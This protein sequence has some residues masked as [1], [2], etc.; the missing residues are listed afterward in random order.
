MSKYINK[1]MLLKDFLNT[2]NYL[3]IADLYKKFCDGVDLC[4]DWNEFFT[5]LEPEELS[6]LS[7]ASSASWQTKSALV[8]PTKVKEKIDE[9]SNKHPH[10]NNL[11]SK[12][13]NLIEAYRNYGHLAVQLDPLG[14]QDNK[15]P[16]E[17]N[18]QTYKITDEE[19]EKGSFYGD[20]CQKNNLTI[21][22]LFKHLV[23]TY[24]GRVGIEF[25]HME[26]MTERDWLR[27]RFE[28]NAGNIH[29]TTMEQ[30]EILQGIKDVDML[31]KFLHTKFPGAKRFSIE[32]AESTITAIEQIIKT[33]AHAGVKEAI[34]G[35][36]HRGRL[37]ILTKVM[38]KPYHAL[39]SEFAGGTFIPDSLN[40]PGDVKYHLG[41]SSDIEVDGKK[42]HLTLTHNPSHLEAVSPVVLGRVRAKQKSFKDDC[43]SEVM[44]ILLHGDAA[45]SGQGS[46][47]ET[48]AL[49]NVEAYKVGGTIH[50]ITNNQIGFTTNA[51]SGRSSRYCTDIAKMI[52]A[53]VLHVSG[54]DPEAVAFAAKIAAEYRL[55]FQKDIF[56]D[57]VCY[58][59]FGHNEGDEPMFTQPI[60]YKKI[61]KK[62][63]VSEMYS[64]DLITKN[65]IT[66]QY[67]EQSKQNFKNF[68]QSEF[69]KS[70]HYKPEEA[71][72]LQSEWKGFDSSL[73]DTN[74]IVKTAVSR[75][76]VEKLSSYITQIP[77]DFNAH[78]KIKKIFQQRDEMLSGKHDLDWG[79][80]ETLAYAT[81]LSDGFNIRI[82]GQDVERGTFSHRHATIHDQLSNA[83]Y[84]PLANLGELQKGD[85]E[86][87]NSILS[88]FGVLG[89]E[90]GYSFSSPNTLVIWEA[91]FGDFANGAQVI[92]DQFIVSGKSKWMRMSGLVML[93]PHGYEGQG[94]EHSSARLERFLQLCANDNITV[95]NCTTPASFFHLLRRQMLRK[96]RNPLVVMTPKSFLRHKLA[97]SSLDDFVEKVTFEKLLPDTLVEK[98]IKRIIFCSGKVYYDLLEYRNQN[99]FKNVALVRLEQLYP[100]PKK[101]VQEELQRYH[102]IKD[103]VWCQEEHKN[104]GAWHY[105]RAHFEKAI[106]ASKLEKQIIYI[107]RKKSASPAAGHVKLHQKELAEFI[108]E[109]FKL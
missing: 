106:A 67:F 21:K 99:E 77:E 109:A 40:L 79:M 89:F 65:V 5:A 50:V 23:Q 26:N 27:D 56:I 51:K 73:N 96:V 91:Q 39:F 24:G 30:Q 42:I 72:W 105:I 82:T 48:L 69:D 6:L 59:K 52:S 102:N 53:P 90:Y 54:D 63:P 86:I 14:L 15:F 100:F 25:C 68:L 84:T 18:Y 85:F 17:L 108:S 64:Q 58:R 60:M 83:K 93:L 16:K 94:P 41:S 75:K 80:G 2:S 76:T 32:G 1:E 11:Q 88:E 57:I 98:K 9:V 31:E 8:P 95:A 46:V 71:D 44:A 28:K 61:Q 66:A 37:S 87:H 74:S 49:S 3:Y 22:E 10:D 97:V 43:R 104:M 103:I 81:L 62:I 12:V 33:S 20:F 34:F 13:I 36:A 7:Q 47:M 70:K 55:H 35:M 92:I 101:E 78:A 19:F 29:L 45:F 4:D 38:G 107:G